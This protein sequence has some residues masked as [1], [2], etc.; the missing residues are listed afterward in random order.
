MCPPLQRGEDNYGLFPEKAP[1][2]SRFYA[3]CTDHRSSDAAHLE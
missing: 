3:E 1:G 2:G